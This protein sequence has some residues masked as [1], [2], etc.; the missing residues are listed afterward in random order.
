MQQ[1]NAPMKRN[2]GY[3]NK[4][5]KLR[6]FVRCQRCCNNETI[7]L[8][9]FQ[10]VQKTVA[11]RYTLTVTILS[12]LSVTSSNHKQ[13]RAKL[14]FLFSFSHNFNKNFAKTAEMASSTDAP[15]SK[16]PIL[17]PAICRCCR[18]IKKCRLLGAEYDWMGQKEIYSDMIMDCFGLL[19]SIVIVIPL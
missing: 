13:C 3:V 7:W 18:S 14:A 2:A 12:V 6:T 4:A 11:I 5:T 17:D 16:G 10:M 1:Q 15:K 19:V 9:A 8:V